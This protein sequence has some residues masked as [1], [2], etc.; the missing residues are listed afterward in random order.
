MK[1]YL[2]ESQFDA[3]RERIKARRAALHLPRSI[4]RQ[5]FTRVSARDIEDTTGRDMTL[6]KMAVWSTIIL[7][8]LLFAACLV[9]VIGAFGWG[10]TLAAPLTA[11]FWTILVGLTPERGTP[12]HST[13]GFAI[14]LGLAAVA[15][16]EYTPLIALFAASVWLNHVGYAMAQHWAQQLVTDSFAA[17]DMLVEH[18]RI[19]D[20]EAADSQ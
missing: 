19:D 5:L 3:L 20:P 4:S 6:Q 2:N 1:R 13:A 8:F 16:G 15:P 14:G 18:L 10:A 9:A 17:Y 11:I 7:S 12:W